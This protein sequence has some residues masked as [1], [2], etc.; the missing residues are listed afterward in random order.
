[1]STRTWTNFFD[2]TSDAGFR[3]IGLNVSTNLAALNTGIL[4]VTADTG[5]INW[6]TVTKPVVTSTAAGYEIYKFTDSIGTLYFKIEYGTGG[7]TTS[8]FGMWITIGTGSNGAGTITGILSTRVQTSGAAIVSTTTSYPSYAC[9]INGSFTIVTGVGSNAAPTGTAQTFMG[10]AR[11]CD[12]TGSPTAD[13]YESYMSSSNPAGST[14]FAVN[15]SSLNV[16]STTTGQHALIPYG[17]ASSNFGTG[18][19][20]DYQVW[21]HEIPLPQTFTANYVGSYI[22]SEAGAA[23]TTTMS[24]VGAT[25]HTM[26]FTGA[27][28]LRSAQNLTTTAWAFVYE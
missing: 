4:T 21:R 5:Q 3:V 14:V 26:F 24:L 18:G 15:I 27:A 8:S 1:M 22:A 23:T 16:F 17:I 6:V 25:T 9:C 10:I 28:V 7:T 20:N 2:M 19:N 13:G 11:T 12:S